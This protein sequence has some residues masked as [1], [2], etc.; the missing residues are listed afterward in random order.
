MSDDNS[1]S[2]CGIKKLKGSSDY[3]VWKF[4]TRKY[5]ESKDW[6]KAVEFEGTEL[7]ATLKDTDRK[8]RTTLCLLIEPECYAH[9]FNA[10]TAKQVWQN[11]KTAY[12]DKGWGRRIALQRELWDCRLVNFPSMEKYITKVIFLTQQLSEIDAKVDDDWIIS[13]LLSGL[14]EVY[15]PLI[16]AV[17]NS[18][19]KVSLEQI[20]TKLLQEGNRQA[21]SNDDKELAAFK[22]S[23]VYKNKP[24]SAKTDRKSKCYK[25][26]KWHKPSEE[27]IKSTKHLAGAAGVCSQKRPIKPNNFCFGVTSVSPKVY[28][29]SG[30]CTWW[31]TLGQVL[32][33][34]DVFLPAEASH[35]AEQLLLC[36]HVYIS[37]SLPVELVV[38]LAVYS[39][40]SKPS[41]SVRQ[42]KRLI[43]LNNFCFGII[44][45]IFYRYFSWAP[46]GA[47]GGLH[48]FTW[49][50]VGVPGG[51]H[52]VLQT[53]DVYSPAEASYQAEQ[54]V[55]WSHISISYSLA[56]L[57][58]VLLVVYIWYS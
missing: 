16:M 31:F 58:M 36:S 25:C 43:K 18:G 27:C 20:K 15:N 19:T 26:H 32:Q 5:L 22:A 17:D 9:V 30:W 44:S 53:F 40:Y 14:T 24:N 29:Y 7:P 2:V 49:A 11:L 38:H 55:L 41:M 51:L 52:P 46:V 54:L 42:Q 45:C 3:A 47:P 8:A 57:L 4:A 10:T 56:G 13:I 34:F 48:Q 39:R 33:T 6:Y 37:Y 28:L 23:K 12:E 1:P 50:P 35:Q 21:T